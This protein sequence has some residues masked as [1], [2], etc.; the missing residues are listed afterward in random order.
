MRHPLSALS[1]SSL[2]RVTLPAVGQREYKPQV[3]ISREDFRR[4]GGG[5]RGFRKRF[6]KAREILKL[7]LYRNVSKKATTTAHDI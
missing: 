4:G 5:E 2:L 7:V 3:S 6:L 1:G